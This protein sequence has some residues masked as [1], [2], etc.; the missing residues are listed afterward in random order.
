MR[1]ISHKDYLEYIKGHDQLLMPLKKIRQQ[2]FCETQPCTLETITNIPG[3]PTFLRVETGNQ[4]PIIPS[5]IDVIKE[6]TFK[7]DYSSYEISRVGGI[8]DYKWASSFGETCLV[9]SSPIL[10][11]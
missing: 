4:K 10:I 2:F 11:H 3:Q 7:Q 1:I 5:F 9:Q 8:S 6:V